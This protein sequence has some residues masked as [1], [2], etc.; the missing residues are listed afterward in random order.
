M[1]DTSVLQRVAVEICDGCHRMSR[2][3]FAWLWLGRC[4]KTTPVCGDGASGRESTTSSDSP[5]TQRLDIEMPMMW[6]ERRVA[7]ES[8]ICQSQE[9][10][11]T[12][13]CRRQSSVPQLASGLGANGGEWQPQ[14]VVAVPSS[15]NSALL[16]CW[17]FCRVR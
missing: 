5:Q 2:G 13:T 6:K 3:Q 9:S 15:S 1:E 11:M 14:V 10:V 7:F 17:S 12:P 8:R 4:P 16:F